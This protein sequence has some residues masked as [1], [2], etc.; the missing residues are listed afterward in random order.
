MSRDSHC[1][2]FQVPQALFED[3]HWKI[4]ILL[5]RHKKGYCQPYLFDAKHFP[6]FRIPGQDT[7]DADATAFSFSTS[8]STK[9]LPFRDKYLLP[10]RQ[11]PK[12]MHPARQA[13]VEEDA[14]EVSAPS[15]PSIMRNDSYRCPESLLPY[16]HRLHKA[17][18]HP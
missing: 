16:V 1:Y 4:V 7:F 18:E 17:R 3:G 10:K 14:P 11:K 9:I 8:A 6:S 13:Y 2:R 12:M 15:N 5:F